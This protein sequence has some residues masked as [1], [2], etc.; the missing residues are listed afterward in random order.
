MKGLTMDKHTSAASY[1]TG[2]CTA[3]AGGI[4]L[5]ELTMW[6]GIAATIGTFL[7]NW[8]Y[9]FKEDRRKESGK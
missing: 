5:Q 4:T 6:V 1:I 2:A 8:Y 9:K 3:L 7:V